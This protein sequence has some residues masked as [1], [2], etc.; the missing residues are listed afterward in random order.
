MQNIYKIKRA[1]LIPF[2]IL[3]L[4]LFVLF[5]LSLIT[6]QVWEKIILAVIFVSSL[7][8]GVEAARREIIVDEEGLELKKFFR[9]KNFTWTEITHLGVVVMKN[10][11]YFLLTTTKGFYIFS[12][13]LGNHTSLIRFLRD[14]LGQEKVE[15]E[16][17]NYLEHPIE[18]LSLIVMSWVAVILIS[19]IILLKLLLA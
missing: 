5:V 2:S 14:K 9:I 4:L 10:K 16:V 13:L 6:G 15:V 8:I 12:N 19:I 17:T 3:I 1:F 7:A 18:R 11:A